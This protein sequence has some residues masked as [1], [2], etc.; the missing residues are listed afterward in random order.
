MARRGI[1]R[2]VAVIGVLMMCSAVSPVHADD[3]PPPN[4]GAFSFT[5]NLNF[6]TAYYF[7]GIAQSN[8]GFQFQPYLELKANVYEGQEGALLSGGFL[9]A[10]GFAHF[11]SVADSIMTN[12]YE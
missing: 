6:P 8:A 12:Y 4:T 10:A 2:A 11:Q 9:K 5:V 1:I 3:A 7:R